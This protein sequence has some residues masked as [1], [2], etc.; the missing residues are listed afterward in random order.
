MLQLDDVWERGEGEN[1]SDRKRKKEMTV[2]KEWK[3][4][5]EKR[6]ADRGLKRGKKKRKRKIERAINGEK[7]S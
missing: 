7:G 5:R 6:E 1:Q 2:G 4:C 3:G